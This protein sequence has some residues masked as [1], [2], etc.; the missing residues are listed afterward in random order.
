MVPVCFPVFG[1]RCHAASV[2]SF[3][4][5]AEITRI[6]GLELRRKYVQDVCDGSGNKRLKSVSRS[7]SDRQCHAVSDPKEREGMSASAFFFPGMCTGD[8]GHARVMLMR[9]ASARI[10]WAAT[11]HC[12][13]ANRVAQLTVGELSLKIVT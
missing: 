7:L 4:R 9:N 6:A 8:S 5:K 11:R 12:F 10:R 2:I 13:V 3:V 1:S